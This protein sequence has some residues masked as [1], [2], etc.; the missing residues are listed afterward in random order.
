MDDFRASFQRGSGEC[1]AVA[2]NSGA[3]EHIQS[4]CKQHL[5]AAR[6]VCHPRNK[7]GGLAENGWDDWEV[8]L[9]QVVHEYAIQ[10]DDKGGKRVVHRG[11]RLVHAFTKVTEGAVRNFHLNT[12]AVVPNQSTVGWRTPC[13]SSWSMWNK[14][15]A[16]PVCGEVHEPPG[17]ADFDAPDQIVEVTQTRL[18]DVLLCREVEKR[19]MKFD[20]KASQSDVTFEESCN[21]THMGE[22][23]FQIRALVVGDSRSLLR[24]ARRNT[25][26]ADFFNAYKLEDY[27]FASKIVGVAETLGRGSVAQA[28]FYFAERGA[29]RSDW[30]WSLKWDGSIASHLPC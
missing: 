18:S 26:L 17:V 3:A 8:R 6:D 27:S 29:A 21:C 9:E 2:G 12:A 22:E 7:H 15:P 20:V 25:K 1:A 24:R 19:K 11:E 4:T 10:S 28:E 16:Q 14:D 13:P 23:R 5:A 30:M